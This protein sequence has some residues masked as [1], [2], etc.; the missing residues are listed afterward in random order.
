MMSANFL[1]KNNDN[2]DFGK[3]QKNRQTVIIVLSILGIAIIFFGVWQI[4]NRIV[5]PFILDEVLIAKKN[6]SEA[7]LSDYIDSINIDTDGDGLS[8]YDEQYLYGTSPYLE[9]TDSDGISDKVEIERGT[10][11]KCPEGQNCLSGNYFA[12]QSVNSD[13]S[14][15]SSNN[16]VLTNL[17]NSEEF[18]DEELRAMLAGQMDAKVLRAFLLENGVEQTVLDNISDEELLSRFNEELSSS[19]QEVLN[20]QNE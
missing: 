3:R 8:D 6:S 15:N 7:A 17:N 10:D 16:L 1:D 18:T 5:S 12:E 13:L 2:Y 4:R 20:K 19:Y 11:P 9:D 14:A